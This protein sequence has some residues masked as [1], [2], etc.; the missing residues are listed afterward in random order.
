MVEDERGGRNGRA[1]P[2]ELVQRAFR[3]RQAR[4]ECLESLRVF[5]CQGRGRRIRDAG[6]EHGTQRLR[7]RRVHQ[8]GQRRLVSNPRD[9]RFRD[10]TLD[11]C[12][13]LGM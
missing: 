7:V 3:P 11:A 4:Q 1:V 8:P 9:V 13:E 6:A 10:E 12:S 2:G 5:R